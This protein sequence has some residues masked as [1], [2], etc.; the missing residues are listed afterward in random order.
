MSTRRKAGNGEGSLFR[1]HKTLPGG[2]RRAYGNWFVQMRRP[3]GKLALVNLDTRDYNEAR[4]R[5]I[6]LLADRRPGD[7]AAA[8]ATMTVIA[9]LQGWFDGKAAESQSRGT[10]KSS[11]IARYKSYV[12]NFVAYLRDTGLEAL[13]LKN[14]TAGHLAHVNK[15]FSCKSW[16]PKGA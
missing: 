15:F 12:G 14:L 4:Q 16:T 8:P 9:F 1:K 10:V 5:R 6:K 13:A 3:D 2:R 7:F 11:T